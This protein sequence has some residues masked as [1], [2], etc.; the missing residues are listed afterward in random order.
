MEDCQHR[1]ERLQQGGHVFPE[2]CCPTAITPGRDRTQ[3]TQQPGRTP[4]SNR[5][6]QQMHG[7]GPHSGPDSEHRAGVEAQPGSHGPAAEPAGSPTAAEAGASGRAASA[8]GPG[9]L[10]T[11]Q[12]TPVGQAGAA[13]PGSQRG[14]LL[15]GQ[16]QQGASSQAVCEATEGSDGD[17]PAAVVAAQPTGDDPEAA[18]DAVGR[19]SPE[20]GSAPPAD[21]QP[22]AAQVGPRVASQ[23]PE[24]QPAQQG[25]RQPVRPSLAG[26]LG[27]DLFPASTQHHAPAAMLVP[28]TAKGA[29]AETGGSQLGQA[30][31]ASLE[32]LA[33]DLQTQQTQEVARPLSLP[34][35]CA[36]G[37]ASA[38]AA[39]AAATAATRSYQA[40]MAA[41]VGSAGGKVPGSNGDAVLLAA[42]L[43]AQ[44]EL[45]R[46]QAELSAQGAAET[47]THVPAGYAA[48]PTAA[49][50]ACGGAGGESSPTRSALE[51]PRRS[52]TSTRAKGAQAGETQA[53][54]R[55]FTPPSLPLGF[56]QSRS[57]SQPPHRRP[58]AEHAAAAGAADEAAPAAVVHP[59]LEALAAG[60]AAG[61]QEPFGT[62]QAAALLADSAGQTQQQN[63]AAGADL[64][65]DGGARV[66][67][68][69]SDGAVPFE[70][71]RSVRRQPGALLTSQRINS[72]VDLLAMNACDFPSSTGT[73]APW[74]CPPRRV[75]QCLTG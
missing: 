68:G 73:P 20:L 64:W 13:V 18:G 29:A 14:R 10:S 15:S 38:A 12:A 69:D 74:S 8:L 46:Q 7:G 33:L 50:P 42:V 27:M 49:A 5:S 60:T 37:L 47:P 19:R 32:A 72:Q 45:A 55:G 4:H 35:L 63:D 30:G 57:A 31:L 22:E 71:S 44:P 16:P 1:D 21:S 23:W 28:Q 25:A 11:A 65:P 17:S 56:L 6:P 43:D 34:S 66:D 3:A 40:R 75:S 67:P 24:S 39:A 52:S 36:P 62:Q 53:P 51:P 2:S 26:A 41:E 9:D 48:T 61:P 59:D 58:G 54:V 70:G